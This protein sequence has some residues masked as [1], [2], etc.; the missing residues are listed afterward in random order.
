MADS[1]DLQVSR[2]DSSGRYQETLNPFTASY[3]FEMTV[4]CAVQ[5]LNDTTGAVEGYSFNITHVK[6]SHPIFDCADGCTP[7]TSKYGEASVVYMGNE[8]SDGMLIM[9][10]NGAAIPI[11]QT[12]SGD[13]LRFSPDGKTINIALSGDL[14]YGNNIGWM[15]GYSGSRGVLSVETY[16]C[17]MYGGDGYCSVNSILPNTITLT[18]VS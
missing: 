17:I 12:T 16:N 11:T 1:G 6:A 10:P 5:Y 13:D 18:K 2:P 8:G 9:F 7:T 15:P 3:D 4:K 14:R